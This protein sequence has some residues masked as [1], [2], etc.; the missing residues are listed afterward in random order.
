MTEAHRHRPPRR[1]PDSRLHTDPEPSDA[2][3]S[4]AFFEELDA[5]IAGTRG[6]H[7]EESRATLAR[8]RP[9]LVKRAHTDLAGFVRDLERN[10]RMIEDGG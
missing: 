1:H 7:S 4:A 8:L 9:T 5:R 10:I 6:T 2:A 3:K